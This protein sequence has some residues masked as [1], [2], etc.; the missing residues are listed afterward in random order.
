M[1]TSVPARMQAET[2]VAMQRGD[3]LYTVLGELLLTYR[4]F[5]PC[6]R[7]RWYALHYWTTVI[8]E[9]EHSQLG[10][11]PSVHMVLAR[12]K[13]ESRAPKWRLDRLSLFCPL[14][15]VGGKKGSLTAVCRLQLYTI[16]LF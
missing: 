13:F 6:N 11:I 1:D 4:L 12:S 2:G 16:F 7:V 10:C 14:K 8:V 5:S 3:Q 15:L 9:D